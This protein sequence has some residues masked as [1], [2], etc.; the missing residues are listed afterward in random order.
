MPVNYDNSSWFYDRLSR[1]VYG[2]AL[3]NAQ[4]YL[5][6]HI[7]AG[8]SVLIV[9]GG[10][11]WIIEEIAKIHPASL[12]IT[13]VE[14]SAKMIALSR[15]RQVGQ[16]RVTFINDAIESATPGQNF[17]VVITAFLFDN[18]SDATFPKVFN[19]VS[20][21]LKAGGVWLNTDFQLTGKWWQP[22]LLNAMLLF[23][24]LLCGVEAARL[25]N[26]DGM[27]QLHN[28]ECIDQKAFFWDFII[29]GA[30]RKTNTTIN[31]S[32]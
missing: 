21:L 19:R 8:A 12:S 4:V 30:W 32:N 10:T 13:Y 14:T 9:G 15:E 20:S 23:F 27:F 28:Y 2:P 26:V 17:D 18:F 24:K 22:V 6:K 29:S 3:V 5:L 16:N 25:P 11:G 7:P 31:N 1:L